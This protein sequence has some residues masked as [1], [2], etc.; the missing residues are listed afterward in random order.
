MPDFLSQICM[1]MS[2]IWTWNHLSSTDYVNL[3]LPRESSFADPVNVRVNT[4]FSSHCR[5]KKDVPRL[6]CCMENRCVGASVHL[7]LV[8]WSCV[9]PSASFYVRCTH[10]S[11]GD[12]NLMQEQRELLF[13]RP[14]SH[15][16][17]HTHPLCFYLY[18]ARLAAS[19]A[20]WFW[21]DTWVICTI[22]ICFVFEGSRLVHTCRALQNEGRELQG[23]CAW[24]LLY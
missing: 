19:L 8:V 20:V 7:D 22:Q 17:T 2:A 9:C 13:M 5:N 6:W 4:G 21:S 12:W 23:H 18:S 10:P 3:E 15:T 24:A 14:A 11:P 1:C 16:H